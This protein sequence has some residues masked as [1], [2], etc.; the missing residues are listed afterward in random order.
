[1]KLNLTHLL[2]LA[3]VACV[4][5]TTGCAS[6]CDTVRAEVPAINAR[7]ADVQRALSEVEKSGL[8][9]RL[10]GDM[11]EAFDDAMT[12]AWQAYELALQSNALA[13]VSCRDPRSYIDIIVQAWDVIH[14]LLALV[15]G[16][17]TPTIAD[18]IVWAEAR[19]R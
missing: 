7:L 11:L 2:T 10:E 14:P 4:A 16:N 19:G 6:V 8:R 18:P 13:D 3:I 12:R 15:G 9:D 17:G 1:M 5:S